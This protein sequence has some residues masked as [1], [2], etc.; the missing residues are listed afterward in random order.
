MVQFSVL[1]KTPEINPVNKKARSI[2]FLNPVTDVYGRV[3]FF[4]WFG[5][6]IAFWSWYGE[7][8]FPQIINPAL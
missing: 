7:L 8:A 5:F 2:P 4:S 6:M 1:W 3:F